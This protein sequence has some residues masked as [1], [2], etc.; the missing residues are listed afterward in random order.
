MTESLVGRKGIAAKGDEHRAAR[1]LCNECGAESIFPYRFAFA[2]PDPQRRPLRNLLKRLIG[3]GLAAF[4]L[5]TVAIPVVSSPAS[6]A[7][8]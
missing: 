5:S 8:R 1:D 7:A 4:V 6:A 2:C 3:T